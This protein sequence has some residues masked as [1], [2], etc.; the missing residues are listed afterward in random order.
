MFVPVDS[1]CLIHNAHLGEIP[2]FCKILEPKITGVVKLGQCTFR[3]SRYVRTF[4]AG[5]CTYLGTFE[6]G[7][8]KY[9]GTCTYLGLL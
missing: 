8:C 4:E 7:T 3:A 9:L 6:T 1:R 2:S 5:T